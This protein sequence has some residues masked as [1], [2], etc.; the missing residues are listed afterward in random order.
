MT[1]DFK[2]LV[3][4]GN[5]KIRPAVELSYLSQEQQKKLY[6]VMSENGITSVDMDTAK[7]MRELCKGCDH[8]PEQFQEILSG[9]KNEKSKE[10]KSYRLIIK[11]AVYYRYLKD[12]PKKEVGGII[13]KALEMYF[14]GVTA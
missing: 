10:I 11:P 9:D 4:T 13:E 2:R 12:V 5:I 14:S 1:D 6:D 8:F 3:D 7:K